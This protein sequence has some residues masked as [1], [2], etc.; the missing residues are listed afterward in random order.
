[1]TI[2]NKISEIKKLQE[3]QTPFEV[4]RLI[5]KV[6]LQGDQISL[7]DNDLDFGSVE[8]YQNALSW[9]VEQLGGKVKWQKE[10]KV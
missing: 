7:S 5:G 4:R 9:L 2:L 6:C 1:M 3:V 10:P 8:E